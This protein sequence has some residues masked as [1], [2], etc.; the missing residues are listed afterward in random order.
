MTCTELVE[1]TRLQLLECLYKIPAWIHAYISSRA[2]TK[3][4]SLRHEAVAVVLSVLDE[5]LSSLPVG[6]KSPRE[7]VTSSS[8]GV[9]GSGEGG[10][11]ERSTT[12]PEK[13]TEGERDGIK[14]E[15]GV[16]LAEEGQEE[17]AMKR[18]EEGMDT[19][20]EAGRHRLE[21]PEDSTGQKEEDGEP[22]SDI[23]RQVD[24]EARLQVLLRLLRLACAMVSIL[25][26]LFASFAKH[27]VCP[28]VGGPIAVSFK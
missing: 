25:H 16:S 20:G 26:L 27:T 10:R 15:N 24:K 6:D 1:A 11:V 2:Y 12:E 7:S 23:D 3:A 18:K 17:Q 8:A 21:E 22:V 5:L 4:Q 13:G 19:R 9:E 14:R 28:V